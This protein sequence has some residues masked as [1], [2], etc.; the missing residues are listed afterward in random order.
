MQVTKRNGSKEDF[1]LEKIHKVISWAVDGINDVSISDIE[2]NAKLNL[3]DG[4]STEEIHKLLIN[5]ANNLISE[6]SPNYQYVAA[7]LL[8][9]SLRKNVWGES[10]PPRL[11]DHIKDT[12]NSEVYDKI[13]LEK[14]SESE[15]HKIGKFVK[16]SRDDLFTYAGLQQLV[17]KYLIKNRYTNEIF[18]TPQFAYML[19]AM[20]A[21]MDYPKDIRIS[22]VKKCYDYI[23][24]F[25]INLPTPLM[26]GLRTNIRQYSSCILID[27]D[28]S[29]DSIFAS[30]EAVGKYTARRAGIGTNTGRIRPINSPIRGGEV[31]HTGIIPYLKIFESTV[32]STSQN[33]IRGGSAT[34]NVQFWHHEIE[35]IVVLKNNTGTDDNRVRK[36]DYLIGLSKLFYDR[37]KNDKE[38]TL[39]SPHECKDLYEAFGTDKFD[40]LYVEKENDNSLNFKKKIKARDLAILLTRERLETGRIYILNVDNANNH[41][42]FYDTVKMGNLCTEVLHPLIPLKSINDENAEIGVCVLSAVNLLEIKKEEFPDVCDIIVR[43]LDF[44]IDHQDYVVKA[45]ENF[46]KNRRSIGVG[47]TNLA[48]VLAKNKLAYNSKEALE[49][50]DEYAEL[51]Q[52]N[53][54]SASC[55]LAEE[56][57]VCS[58]FDRTK[59]SDGI[60]PI[61]TYNKNVDSLVNPKLRCDWDSLRENIKKYGLRHSTLTCQMPCESSS[62]IQ[63]STNGIEPVRELISY[64]KSKMGVLK[65]VVPGFS[66][67]G[68]Y[69]TRA[70]SIEDNS[71]L[72]NVG[73][74]IQKWFDMGIS[75]NHYYNYD[76]YEG[77]NVPLSTILKDL[78]YAHKMGIKTLY[79]A[80]TP[81]G[82]MESCSSGACSI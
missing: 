27:V 4:I 45:A 32:K 24:T 75:L 42:P 64:K 79:Y 52:F 74:V 8:L 29:L 6:E 17:D 3:K 36:L 63:N 10:E 58:K 72:T 5:S 78:F 80:N 59:Y 33:G 40:D 37:V 76:H 61:D 15:I 65:Q 73:A 7:R 12:V 21:F 16:H 14:Y 25:K 31:K 20:F 66:K 39:F 18:E 53:L 28:D 43:M 54:L 13:I 47:F 70:F 1:N 9:Y 55:K 38:I 34:N 82:D 11:F 81:D 69:Y 68:K 46:C 62:V 49:L 22:Y 23:S 35:D 44:I 2:M 60:L 26:C 67:F 19:I 57:G 48:G 30:V 50:I 71:V 41:N 51:L 56:K 77:G